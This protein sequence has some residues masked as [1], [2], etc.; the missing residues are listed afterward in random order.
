MIHYVENIQY[1]A[2]IVG[3]ATAGHMLV[4]LVPW[5][6]GPGDGP[7][8][9]NVT[10]FKLPALGSAPVF[11]ASILPWLL[12]AGVSAPEEAFVRLTATSALAPWARG[13]GAAAAAAAQRA[14][15]RLT[16][17]A[18]ADLAVATDPPVSQGHVGLSE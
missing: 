5:A 13:G 6:A 9:S 15:P 17:N 7:P 10:A 18:A 2:H 16:A 11:N 1:H 4:E 12:A 3:R 8:I 14:F